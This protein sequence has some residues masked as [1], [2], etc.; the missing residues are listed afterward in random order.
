MIVDISYQNADDIEN[1]VTIVRVRKSSKRGCFFDIETL[2]NICSDL[3]MSFDR[4]GGEFHGDHFND[5]ISNAKED[6]II[7]I[8]ISWD[9]ICIR[10]SSQSLP[11][12]KSNGKLL[13]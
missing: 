2:K 3:S 7:Q 1:R 11:S 10:L 6:V 8:E 9:D 12:Y 13:K 4:M 5:F